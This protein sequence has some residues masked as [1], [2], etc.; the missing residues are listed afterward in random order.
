MAARFRWPHPHNDGRARAALLAVGLT[1]LG[2]MAISS[3][4]V[5]LYR[6]VSARLV[7]TEPTEVV[8]FV[9]TASAPA[10]APVVRSRT[11][12]RS[13]GPTPQAPR[14]IEA[15]TGLTVAPT[16]AREGDSVAAP[17]PGQREVT[18]AKTRV[19]PQLSS[20]PSSGIG[21][22]FVIDE[23]AA[24]ERMRRD[25]QILFKEWRPTQADRDAMWREASLRAR[26][27]RADQRPVAQGGAGGGMSIPFPLFSAGPSR[28]QRERDSI[29]HAE[30]LRTLERLAALARAR[31]DSQQRSKTLARVDTLQR[32]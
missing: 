9:R 10:V 8:R 13:I 11:P 16:R 18:A 2:A 6:F 29:V 26:L 28:K 23:A 5:P 14:S 17:A 3:R 31:Q 15:D 27:A 12:S 20:A 7:S 1:A 22:T 19:G 24:A 32:P 4:V 30:N 21:R 25:I